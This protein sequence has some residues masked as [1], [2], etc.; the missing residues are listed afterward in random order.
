MQTYILKRLLL[1]VPILV[2]VALMVFFMIRLVP[3][4]V[5]MTQIGEGGNYNPQKLAQMKKKMGLDDPVF[6][7]LGKWTS[8][9]VRGDFGKSL[10]TD[11][12]TLGSFGKAAKVTVEIGLLSIILGLL[13]AIPL[14]VAAA[15]KQDTWIDYVSRIIATVGISAPDFWIATAFIVF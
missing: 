5:L 12:S 9:V 13:I 7:Q 3:G 2:I 10:L 15:A 14:G 4:N 8:K 11:K 1:T 6:I